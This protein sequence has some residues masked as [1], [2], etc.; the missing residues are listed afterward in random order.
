MGRIANGGIVEKEV[1]L[2]LNDRT[3]VFVS[4]SR[5]D[6]STAV[7]MAEGINK[8]LGSTPAAT[9]DSGR[10]R[11]SIP[12]RY[13]NRVPE[14]VAAIENI[15]IAVDAPAKVV[16]NERTG[17]VV[18]GEDVRIA[19]VAIAH[20]NLTVSVKTQVEV[21][22]PRPFSKGETVVVPQ[23]EVEVEEQEARLMVLR[24]GVSVDEMVRA[25][26]S[27]GVTPRDLIAILQAIKA[28]GALYAELEI[29]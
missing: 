27:V 24:P 16:L 28:A 14:L 20:G 1:G 12:D 21:S 15:E 2:D 6:F 13:R 26:N 8:A 23:R 11:V 22:Q 25:L 3:D 29:I 10:V 5:Q 7:R 17:T 19:T 4:L 18:M 9:V